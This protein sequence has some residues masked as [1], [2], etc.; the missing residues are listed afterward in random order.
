MRLFLSTLAPA[1]TGGAREQVV[2]STDGKSCSAATANQ[3]VRTVVAYESEPMLRSIVGV[4]ERSRGPREVREMGENRGGCVDRAEAKRVAPPQHPD[5]SHEPDDTRQ[6][7][8]GNDDPAGV[9]L[10]IACVLDSRNPP[11]CAAEG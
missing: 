8:E 10:P 9:A 3:P 4:A 11:T 2:A 7:H 1:L 6:L 5:P